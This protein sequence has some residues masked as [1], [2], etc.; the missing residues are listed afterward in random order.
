ML[1]SSLKSSEKGQ[2][3]IEVLVALAAA[4]AVVTAI[5][6][7]VITS[8][9][10][11]EFTKNQN[12]AT[13]YARQGAEYIRKIA[14]DNFQNFSKNYTSPSYCLD[15]NGNLTIM[16]G[17]DCGLNVGCINS[18]CTF[19]RRIDLV[20]TDNTYCSGNTKVSATV[21]WSDS[22]CTSLSAPFCHNVTVDSCLANINSIQAP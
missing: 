10:N 9:G 13:Q 20:Q 16:L 17:S 22:K 5:A 21:E 1:N 15:Q 3:I 4:V 18:I 7:T 2:T 12:L 6:I 8:L 11:V 19:V 14:K